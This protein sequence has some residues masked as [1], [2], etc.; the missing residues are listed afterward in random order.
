M[1]E[2]PQLQAGWDAHG[3]KRARESLEFPEKSLH[4]YLL[5]LFNAETRGKQTCLERT[6]MEMEFGI[7]GK[8]WTMSMKNISN[9]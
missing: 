9:N 7:V 2:S 5:L 8:G 3:I 6:N 1:A 4:F